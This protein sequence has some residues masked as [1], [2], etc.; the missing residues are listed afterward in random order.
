MFSFLVCRPILTEDLHWVR[1]YITSLFKLFCF[2]MVLSSLIFAAFPF[3]VSDLILRCAE[4]K[5]PYTATY[6][7][8]GENKPDW[9]VPFSSILYLF[10]WSVLMMNIP[11]VVMYNQFLYCCFLPI[12]M[13]MN[14]KHWA[15]IWWHLKVYWKESQGLDACSSW[16]RRMDSRLGQNCWAPGEEVPGSPAGHSSGVQT[17]VSLLRSWAQLWFMYNYLKSYLESNLWSIC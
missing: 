11:G 1:R 14:C 13:Q 3:L 6:I 9:Y 17:S 12:I 5:L 4:K 15:W 10:S 8:E 2:P 16:W 7:E